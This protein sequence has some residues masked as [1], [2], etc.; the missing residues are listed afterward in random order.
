M[1]LS[2]EVLLEIMALVQD[3]ILYGQDISEKLREVDLL[4]INEELVLTE[5]YKT[6]NPRATVWPD[7]TGDS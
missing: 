7:K 6:S 5:D 2:K 1:K 4:V 3:G